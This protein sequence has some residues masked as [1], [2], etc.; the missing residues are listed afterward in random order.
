MLV[1][2]VDVGHVDILAFGDHYKPEDCALIWVQTCT[3]SYLLISTFAKYGLYALV[4]PPVVRLEIMFVTIRVE[5]WKLTLACIEEFLGWRTHLDPVVYLH[6]WYLKY[7]LSW[8][9]VYFGHIHNL[10]FRLMVPF[11]NWNLD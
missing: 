2:T 4:R 10:R 6:N 5:T 1:A 3:Y 11:Y 7:T 9:Y 8:I